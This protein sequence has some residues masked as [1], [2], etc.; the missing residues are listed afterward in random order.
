MND[1]VNN[2]YVYDCKVKM[3]PRSSRVWFHHSMIVLYLLVIILTIY[4][5]PVH[6][7]LLFIAWH[8]NEVSLKFLTSW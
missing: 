2:F 1:R 4:K 8:G 3:Q 7:N 5:G 6:A